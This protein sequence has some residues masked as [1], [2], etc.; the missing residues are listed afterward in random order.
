M[1]SDGKVRMRLMRK[2][3]GCM[4]SR[5]DGELMRFCC[6]SLILIIFLSAPRESND[7]SRNEDQETERGRY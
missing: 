2:D 4:I 7:K 1:Q 3:C 6:V 5:K